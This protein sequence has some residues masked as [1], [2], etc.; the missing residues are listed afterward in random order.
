MSSSGMFLRIEYPDP[1]IKADKGILNGSCN[2]QN[3]QK[4]GASWYNQ[5]NH[6]Y[7]CRAC[8]I[9]INKWSSESVDGPPV[10]V[11]ASYIEA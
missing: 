2:R 3:C 5:N 4:P 11:D 9:E 1:D 10:C 8:A 6:A 7:Y